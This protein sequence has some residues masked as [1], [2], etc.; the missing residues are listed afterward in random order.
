MKILRRLPIGEEPQ[1][2]LVGN[3]PVLIRRYQIAVWVR[4]REFSSPAVFDTGHSHNFSISETHLNEWAGIRPTSLRVIG[5][6]REN[7][8]RLPQLQTD[9]FLHRN[10]PGT[11][12]RAER[13]I[14][15]RMDQGI[16]LMPERL[17]RLPILGLRALVWNDLKLVMDGKRRQVTLK[18]GWLRQE[19]IQWLIAHR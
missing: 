12:E 9:V 7:E 2:I 1:T 15:L 19:M 11:I 6:T 4:L 13:G 14:L 8:E 17:A 18:T 3:E 10:E 16:S 5:R